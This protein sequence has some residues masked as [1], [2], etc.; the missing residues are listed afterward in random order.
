MIKPLNAWDVKNL[1]GSL[2]VLQ[3]LWNFKKKK[4]KDTLLHFVVIPLKQTWLSP[5]ASDVKAQTIKSCVGLQSLGGFVLILLL[6]LS[7]LKTTSRS[8][9]TSKTGV[10]SPIFLQRTA[11]NRWVKCD[12]PE[13]GLICALCLLLYVP[14]S[15]P[16]LI[17]EAFSRHNSTNPLLSAGRNKLVFLSNVIY[18]Q[19]FIKRM[20]VKDWEGMKQWGNVESLHVRTNE[21]MWQVWWF[22]NRGE[23][24][25]WEVSI[26][27]TISNTQWSLIS[28]SHFHTYL[29]LGADTNSCCRFTFH[30]GLPGWSPRSGTAGL[31]SWHRCTLC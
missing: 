21:N 1:T 9:Q 2:H 7:F 8:H 31:L 12:V 16:Y 6:L 26:I 19:R 22:K 11:A 14:E 15:Y 13:E 3:I 30:L 17:T 24:A 29:F 27:T 18:F 4:K 5:H 25:Q 20:W 23:F 28:L 10:T